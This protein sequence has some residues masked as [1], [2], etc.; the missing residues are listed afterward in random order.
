MLLY[1][2]NSQ[3]DR[4]SL[5]IYKATHVLRSDWIYHKHFTLI[6]TNIWIPSSNEKMALCFGIYFNTC[7]VLLDDKNRHHIDYTNR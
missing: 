5:I 6:L 2:E 4:H 3:S 1:F 7:H